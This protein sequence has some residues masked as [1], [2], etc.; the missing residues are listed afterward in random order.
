MSHRFWLRGVWVILYQTPQNDAF[1]LFFVGFPPASRRLPAC[2]PLLPANQKM[3]P[4]LPAN[5]KHS[6]RE[7]SFLDLN[8]KFENFID[9]YRHQ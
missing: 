2:F 3:F 5:G 8:F 9:D 1:Y 7:I 6:G 4:L